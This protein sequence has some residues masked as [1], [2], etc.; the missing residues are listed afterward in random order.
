MWGIFNLRMGIA[1]ITVRKGV[2]ILP[3][4][5]GPVQ[6]Q[7]QRKIP[8]TQQTIDITE[9]KSTEADQAAV[10]AIQ[11]NLKRQGARQYQPF[12]RHRGQVP[13]RKSLALAPGFVTLLRPRGLLPK[14]R[15]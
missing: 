7:K 4:I 9:V 14:Y 10:Q 3:D 1:C 11:P 8:M 6:I 2:P 15:C 5:S 13:Q 12:A